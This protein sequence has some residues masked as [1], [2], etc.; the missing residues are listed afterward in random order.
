MDFQVIF[1]IV[2]ALIVARMLFGVVK[3]RGFRGMMFGAPLGATVGEI[4]LGS[5]GLVNTK[6]KVH[7][8]EPGSDGES[9]IGVE[10]VSWTFGSYR[11]LPVRLTGLQAQELT[12]LLRQAIEHPYGGAA[13]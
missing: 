1:F 5:R 4:P 7:H 2:F 6:I 8:L 3:N 13:A 11:M 9:M 12:R 10:I